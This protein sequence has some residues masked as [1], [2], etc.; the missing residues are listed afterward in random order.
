MIRL[1]AR[2][3]T[4]ISVLFAMIFALAPTQATYAQGAHSTSAHTACARI[5]S[6]FSPTVVRPGQ[7]VTAF[8]SVTNCS[9]GT[10]NVTVILNTYGPC[11]ARRTVSQPLILN[12]GQAPSGTQSFRAPSCKGTYRASVSVYAG[13]TQIAS[14]SATFTVR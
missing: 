11:N 4:G 14:S 12:S 6:H 9:G 1:A 2:L 3:I 8:G 10:E 5:A 7:T 13:S